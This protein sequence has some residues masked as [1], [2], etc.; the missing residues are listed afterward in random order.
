VLGAL[1][2]QLLSDAGIVRAWEPFDT[3]LLI[4]AVLSVCLLLSH[5]LHRA[6]APR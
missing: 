3:R 5:S 1:A 4:A 6:L 2:T